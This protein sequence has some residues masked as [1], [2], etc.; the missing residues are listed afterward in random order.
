MPVKSEGRS[1]EAE[2]FRI[3]EA[4]MTQFDDA[5]ELLRHCEDKLV[6]LDKQHEECVSNQAIKPEFRIAVKNFTEN[7]RSALDYCALA[8]F[9]RYGKKTKSTPRIYFPYAKH[10]EDRTTFREVTVEKCIPG[11]LTSRPDIVDRLET[12]Q[13]FGNTGNWLPLLAEITN[14]NKH[15]QLTPHVQREHKGVIIT[16]TIPPGG[17]IEIDLK[18]I[19]LGGGPDRPFTAV[20]IKWNGL[21]FASTGVLVMPLLAQAVRIGRLI[22]NEL[23]SL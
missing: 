10:G 18:N 7:L 6:E 1:L 12:Y 19:P 23:S 8:L 17:S 15:K 16:G 22:V 5:R 9:A 2:E 3:R 13:Y 21:E 11:L 14:E 20:P 4:A